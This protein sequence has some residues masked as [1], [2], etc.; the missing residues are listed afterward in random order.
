M[1]S[2]IHPEMRI[3]E[4][5]E[6]YPECLSVFAAY[7]LEELVGE[8]AMRL[9][10][11][12]LTLG[13]ALRTRG[14]ALDLFLNSLHQAL[15][16]KTP[17]EAPGLHEITDG[18][19][20]SLLGLLP[21]G[22]KV[23]FAKAATRFFQDYHSHASAP[24][25]YAVEGNVNQE[26]S[27]YKFVDQIESLDELPDIIVS[28]DFNA[29]FY[30]RFR[31]RF[32]DE[33]YFTDVFPS[34]LNTAFDDTDILDPLGQFTMLTVNPL[35]IVAD[36]ERVGDRPLPTRWSDLLDPMWRRSI[37]LRGDSQ[38]FCHAVLLPFF[39]DHGTSAMTALAHNV[40]RGQH[41][42]QM[43]K[44]AGADRPEGAALYVMP[45]FFAHKIARPDKVR[46][47]WPEEG[48]LISPVTML[49][50]KQRAAQLKTV[51]D[52][53]TGA[54]LAKVF[55]G[56]WFPSPHPDVTNTLPPGA[57]LKWLGW[58][59]LRHNDLAEVN[60]AIDEIFLPAV[61]KGQP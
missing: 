4:L 18:S 11:P 32:I 42:A 6:A 7:G 45:D 13:T 16:Q 46:I 40:L 26:L 34:S 33:G 24:V 29:F 22:L 17:L 12:F 48:G 38:F 9:L 19:R 1:S 39:K 28:S 3:A 54:E 25:T 61:R 49:V 21:C 35:I 60:A 23:P 53:L 50:K 56:A 43:V 20:L 31:K 15:Q 2:K 57:R 51:T 58:D 41:P 30:R 37:T 8:D 47:I 27:Y 36:L 59:Y 44:E 55:A 10:A 5:V 52:F 14:I